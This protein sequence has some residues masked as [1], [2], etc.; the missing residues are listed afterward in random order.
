MKIG[1][2]F[3]ILL[4]AL[5]SLGFLIND[6]LHTHSELTM[7]NRNT[8][9]LQTEMEQIKEQVVQQTA[10]LDILSAQNEALQEQNRTLQTRNGELEQQAQLHSTEIIRLQAENATL[11]QTS[12]QQT[13]NAISPSEQAITL[14][15]LP[16]QGMLLAVGL[17]VPSL[18]AGGS[19]VVYV[20][21][22]HG[23]RRVQPGTYIVR[24]SP[25]ELDLL[26]RHRRKN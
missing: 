12:E 20:L 3:I 1:N 19:V 4:L 17:L 24:V 8:V 13:S 15:R 18:L 16:G 6:S 2:F 5:V 23:R 26:I 25:Y 11:R 21:Q 7:A 22:K 10:E 14:D 9:S